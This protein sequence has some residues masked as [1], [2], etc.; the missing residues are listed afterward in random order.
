MQQEYRAVDWKNPT[1]A[2]ASGVEV[3]QAAGP[4]RGVLR[5][6]QAS[7]TVP[8]QHLRILPSAE[9]SWCVEHYWCVHWD[10]RDQPAQLA[11]TLPHPS[12]HWVFENGRAELVGVH[13][14]RF[15]RELSGLGRVFG[16]KFKP[17]GLRPWIDRPISRLTDHRLPLADMIDPALAECLRRAV[18]DHAHEDLAAKSAVEQHLRSAMPDFDPQ[19]QRISALV[20]GIVHDR[21]ILRVR[22]LCEQ[23]QLHERQ[24]QRLFHEYVGVS[25]KWV[26]NRYRLHEAL[27][28]L[29]RGAQIDWAQLALQLGYYDQAHFIGDFRDLVGTTP[30]EYAKQCM[31]NGAA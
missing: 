10:L 28:H 17:G 9:L 20:L 1:I 24:L 21:S 26:I 12:A 30:G 3:N 5:S 31:A 15:S 11:Q 14:A 29:H 13:T 23:H 25:P 8:S 7:P 4:A 6:G 19:V 27:E 2:A 16:I 22:Q 18:Q